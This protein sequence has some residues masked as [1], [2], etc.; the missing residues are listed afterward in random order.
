MVQPRCPWQAGHTSS[1]ITASS[2]RASSIVEISQ[3]GLLQCLLVLL[4]TRQVMR[5]LLHPAMAQPSR[6]KEA[7]PPK[8]Q[9]GW[10]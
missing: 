8:M 10:R 2:I 5:P 3:G 4:K 6:L 9:A 7:L 1:S